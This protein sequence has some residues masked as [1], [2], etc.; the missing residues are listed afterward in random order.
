MYVRNRTTTNKYNSTILEMEMPDD[1]QLYKTPT[2]VTHTLRVYHPKTDFFAFHI[3][4][5]S[6][7]F[8]F[9]L[10]MQNTDWETRFL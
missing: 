7:H 1:I 9:M 2:H 10:P 3:C 4:V 5:K 6:N 8:H